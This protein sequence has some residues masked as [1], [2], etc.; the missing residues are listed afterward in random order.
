MVCTDAADIRRQAD[1][2]VSD[3][4]MRY[5]VIRAHISNYPD[6]VRFAIGDEI[7]IGA[8]ESRYKG[9]Y[10]VITRDGNSGWAPLQ[11][12]DFE[13]GRA[14]HDYSAGELTTAVDDVLTELY[15]LNGWAW[16]QDVRGDCGW[17]P[18]ETVVPL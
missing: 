11:Y 7:T 9:W 10:R 12:L 18:L 13:R 2:T 4:A 17:V 5:R 8:E 16:M 15:R 14:T 3:Q 1:D 6:P